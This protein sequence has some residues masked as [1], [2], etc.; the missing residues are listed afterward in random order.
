MWGVPNDVIEVLVGWP[1]VRPTEE[2][3]LAASLFMEFEND[4][5]PK[6]H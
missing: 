3:W 6:I 1:S 4:L 5:I 2:D